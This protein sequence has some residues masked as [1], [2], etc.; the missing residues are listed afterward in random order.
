LSRIVAGVDGGGSRTR[1]VLAFTD[2]RE[3][4]TVE[5]PKSAVRPG[6]TARSAEVIAS[7]VEQALSESGHGDARIAVLYA[8]LAGVGREEERRA[9]Q[10]ELESRDVA[11]EIVVD[12]DAAIALYDAFGEG[13]GMILIAG[14]GSIAY[15]RGINGAHARSGGWGP[16]FGDEGGGSWIGRRALSI[17]AA[18]ADGREPATALTGAILTAAEVNTVEDLI[19]WAAAATPAALAE[20]APAVFTAAA[21]GD[22]RADALVGLAV[23]E[24]MLHVRS[25][26]VRVFGDERADIPLALAGGLLGKGS[27]LRTRL[28]QRMKSAVPGAQISRGE[29]QPV[30]GAIRAA[31]LHTRLP[32]AP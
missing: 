26:A 4:T 17:V 25:L 14:T 5:G 8:G 3:I 9:L 24:L 13:P 29:V 22:I 28:E 18:A 30:R 2:G 20:L 11:D 15:A 7:L 10:S 32:T 6:E 19:P 21:G 31:V 23:E 1:A 12:T 16:A 27:M